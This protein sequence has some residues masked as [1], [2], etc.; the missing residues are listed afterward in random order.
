MTGPTDSMLATPCALTVPYRP[1]LLVALLLAATAGTATAADN[2]VPLS[3]IV[4]TATRVPQ[5][6]YDLPVSIS[7]VN[8]TQIQEAQPMV[9]LS[10]SLARVPGLVA[11]DRQNYA[12]GLQISSRGFGARTPFGIR[13]VRMIVDGIPATMP[14]GQG[15]SAIFDLGSAQRIEVLRGPFSALYGN[16]SGGVIQ[17]F[18]QDGPPRPTLTPSFWVGSFNSYRAGL[19]FGGQVGKLNYM[20][21]LSHFSTDGYRDHSKA[22]R[23][24]FNGKFRYQASDKTSVTLLVDTLDQPNVQDPLGLTRSEYESD[25]TQ[26]VPVA[27]TF[28]SR[29]TLR[30]WQTGVVIKHKID[31]HNAI[32]LLGYG[33]NRRVQQFLPFTGS[34]GLSSGGV[35]DLHRSF[36]G[37]DARWTH[38]GTLMQSPFTWV[39]GVNYGTMTDLRKGY[40]NDYG[41][42]GVLRRDENDVAY[43]VDEYLQGEWQFTK[44]WSATVGVRHSMVHFDSKDHFI[45]TTNPNDSGYVSYSHTSPVV[46]ILYKLRP[47]LHLYAN[48]GQGFETP[49]FSQL[50]YK[51]S[52]GSGLNFDLKP[53]TSR[54]YEVG[55]KSFATL[56]TELKLA[57]FHIHTVD[58]IVVAQSVGGRTSYK[59]DGATNRDGA[60][61]SID[62]HL[63]HHIDAYLAYSYLHARFEDG[64]IKGNQLPGAPATNVYAQLG[65]HD[66]NSGFYT[67]LDGQLRSKV[68]VNDQN[69]DAADG[70]GVMDWAAGLK[71]SP[72]ERVSFNEFVRVNNLLDKKYVGAVIIADHN[73]RYFE[74]APGRNYM[75]GVTAQASF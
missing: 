40:V 19:K 65:W 22:S 21:D 10:E 51:P 45:T 24:Q 16:A 67:M 13:G 36:A 7:S 26:A 23:D 33:G 53:S 63:R 74:P 68:Y 17:V 25:P 60:E 18:T 42:I 75:I 66:P 43:N 8:Q 6:S 47:R 14:D 49:T 12:Q 50:A 28:N 30:H 62:S 27:Y 5:S 58:E 4:V 15:Y 69:S 29:K 72:A 32:R 1:R 56:N 38:Q 48:Y 35:V 70:Y 46:G 34:F 41:S 64:A 71:Q 55:I 59:N 54:N 61:L 44:R 11:Q 37:T 31:A 20:T 52:G 3:P 73:H 57:A 9:N 2:T 39:A